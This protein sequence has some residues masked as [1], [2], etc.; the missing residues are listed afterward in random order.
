MDVPQFENRDSVLVSLHTHNDRGTGVAASELGLMAGADRVEGTLFGNGERTGNLDIVTMALNMY[1]QGVDP[2]LDFSDIDSIRHMYEQCTRMTVHPRH[3]YGG[4]LVFTAFSGSHQD[5]INKGMK[6]Q[7]ERAAAGDDRWE[8][9]YLPID[10][11]NIGRSYESII[12]IN[13]QSGK[14]GVAYVLNQEFG[15]QL[16]KAMHPEFSKVVQ[17][18][19]ERIG[20]ELTPIHIFELF[21]QEYLKP[22]DP[23]QLDRVQIAVDAGDSVDDTA[24]VTIDLKVNGELSSWQGTGVGPV[25]AFVN[26]LNANTPAE[27]SLEAFSEHALEDGAN[28][29]AVAYVQ[30]ANGTNGTSF[31]VGIDSNVTIAAIRAV[32]SACNRLYT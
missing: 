5:A 6:V 30:L 17:R 9:P 22:T 16:P 13:S 2:G 28:S 29:R 10:P 24:T 1:S 27:V 3:P 20:N 12:R 8:V 26:G 11:Q 25:E 4:D 23:Y 7:N 18:E 21:E 31:G 15:F 32:L 19:T 14:G